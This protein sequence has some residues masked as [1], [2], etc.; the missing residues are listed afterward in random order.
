MPEVIQEASVQLIDRV[1]FAGVVGYDCKILAFCP[2]VGRRT[3]PAKI[4]APSCS[5][6][7]RVLR[8]EAGPEWM[9]PGWNAG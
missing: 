6:A 7:R 2:G 9:L 8:E 1:T 3:F 5:S 4:A